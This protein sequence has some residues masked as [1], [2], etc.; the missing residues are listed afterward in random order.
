MG[1]EKWGEAGS[2]GFPLLPFWGVDRKSEK[3]VGWR[4]INPVLFNFIKAG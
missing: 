3:P 1:S 2:N 4:R